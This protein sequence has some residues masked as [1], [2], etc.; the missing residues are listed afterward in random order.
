MCVKCGKLIQCLYKDSKSIVTYTTEEKRNLLKDTLSWLNET[1]VPLVGMKPLEDLPKAYRM[2]GT[3]CVIAKALTNNV[4]NT[5]KAWQVSID[6]IYRYT[7]REQNEM[8]DDT[9]GEPYTVDEWELPER[10]QE[11]VR[12]FDMGEYPELVEVALL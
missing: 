2:N 3:A 10:V 1:F 7:P 5:N 8:T 6:N 12:L 4:P 11:F 9:Y